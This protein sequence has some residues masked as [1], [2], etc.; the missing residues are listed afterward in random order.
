MRSVLGVIVSPITVDVAAPASVVSQS[1]WG[2]LRRGASSIDLLAGVGQGGCGAAERVRVV[3]GGH[4]AT[5]ATT[6]S[7]NALAPA[8]ATPL[9]GAGWTGEVASRAERSYSSLPEWR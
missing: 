4:R 8:T 1:G 9:M 2:G 3:P 5:L 7:T 6:S